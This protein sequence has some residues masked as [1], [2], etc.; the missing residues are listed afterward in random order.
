[1]VKPT[2]DQTRQDT[3]RGE[4]E[5]GNPKAFFSFVSGTDKA[6]QILLGIN[7]SYWRSAQLVN[8]QYLL[9]RRGEGCAAEMKSRLLAWVCR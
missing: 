7:P 8:A 3:H 1:V 4:N 2:S 9:T 6:L 5:Y